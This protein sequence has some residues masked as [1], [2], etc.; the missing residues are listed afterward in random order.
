[1]GKPYVWGGS[2][3]YGFDCSG[4]VMYAWAAAGVS[5]PHYTVSQ[6]DA[7]SRISESDL[8]PGD[9]IFYEGLGH[10][11]MYVGGGEVVVA[12]TTGTPVRIESMYYD[13]TPVGFGRVN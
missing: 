4:L 11:A 5:L 8:Q 9:L 1:M 2:G 6:Y 13:G 10:V 7:T 12:D 3:P